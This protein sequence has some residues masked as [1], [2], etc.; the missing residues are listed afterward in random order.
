MYLPVEYYLPIWW[1]AL[2]LNVVTTSLVRRGRSLL[3]CPLSSSV[4][5]LHCTLWTQNMW[6][7]CTVNS[8][9]C[10]K[11]GTPLKIVCIKSLCDDKLRLLKA[12][13]KVH[14]S[15]FIFQTNHLIC[16]LFQKSEIRASRQLPNKLHKVRTYWEKLFVHS[17]VPSP[18]LLSRFR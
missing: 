16:I 7:C 4:N 6:T 15:I 8:N 12:T 5:T 17:I 11:I 13:R 1:L 2:N 9:M 14:N 10:L 3:I 18:K